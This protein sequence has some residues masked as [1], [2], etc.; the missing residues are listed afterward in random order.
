[1]NKKGVEDL[2]WNVM[3]IVL[4][5]TAMAF[6]IYWIGDVASGKLIESQMDSKQA[7]LAVDIARPGTEILFEK[8]LTFSGNN[9]TSN[10]GAMPFSYSHFNPKAEY[11]NNGV[12]V[13]G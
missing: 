3:L 10:A 13:N 12:K 7:A 2:L 8:N 9:I 5:A 1:M 4:I 11:E 6:L